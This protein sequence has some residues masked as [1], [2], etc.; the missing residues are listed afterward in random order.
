M[1]DPNTVIAKLKGAIGDAVV[2]QAILAAEADELRAALAAT[3]ARITR[4]TEALDA[5]GV[6]LPDEPAS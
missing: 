2:N 4:L 5:A 3:E 6:E 1:A